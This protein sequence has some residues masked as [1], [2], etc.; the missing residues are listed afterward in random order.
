MHCIG[1][2]FNRTDLQYCEEC[3]HHKLHLQPEV[4][5]YNGISFLTNRKQN[6]K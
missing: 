3:L 2:P 5:H 6:V 1:Y 4:C